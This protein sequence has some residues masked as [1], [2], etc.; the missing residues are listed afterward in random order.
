LDWGSAEH[1]PPDLRLEAARGPAEPAAPPARLEAASDPRREAAAP[2]A[3]CAGDVCQ[4]RVSVPGY[5]P[6]F[7]TSGLR[8]RLTVSALDALRIEPVATVARWLEATGV[9]LDYTPAALDAAQNPGT[10]GASHFKV[11]MRVRLDAWG[12]PVWA[13]ARR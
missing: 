4:P 7:S 2:P 3:P 8:T 5:E 12:T 1:R 11:L 9:R 6:R 13:Q 10:P